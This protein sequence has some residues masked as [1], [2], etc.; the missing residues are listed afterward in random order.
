MALNDFSFRTRWLLL[1][2]GPIK[3]GLRCHLPAVNESEW[4][5]LNVRLRNVRFRKPSVTACEAIYNS[6]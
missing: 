6:R 3:E 5:G 1:I 2:P 4:L